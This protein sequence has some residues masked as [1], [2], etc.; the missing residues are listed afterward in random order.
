MKRRITSVDPWQCAKTF[1]LVYFAV[2][3]VLAIPLGVISR[4]V[5]HAP[6]ETRPSLLLILC[7]PI[8]YAVAA[9]IFVPI[10]CWIYNKAAGFT[11]GIELT[12]EPD[13]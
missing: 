1:A 4:F 11:G 3:L 10:G 8:I 13:A 9:L 6:G 7:L 2:G 5:P 12:L